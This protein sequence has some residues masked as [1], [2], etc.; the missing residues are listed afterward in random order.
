MKNQNKIYL[1]AL[2]IFLVF[3]SCKP[4][5][6]GQFS[7]FTHIKLPEN[8]SA[9]EAD[10]NIKGNLKNNKELLFDLKTIMSFHPLTF[11]T[12]DPWEDKKTNYT[13]TLLKDLLA[14]CDINE[15]ARHIQVI[16]EN[17]Y[18]IPIKLVD[19]NKYEYILAY[20][21]NGE[22]LKEKKELSKKGSFVIA[23]NFDKHEEIEMQVYKNQLVWQVKYIVV[24]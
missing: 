7:D 14:F 2:F 8:L 19:I 12:Y 3:L 4:S 9:K 18:E 15:T 20:K 6:T 5:K 1:T 24:N 21:I 22:L 10:L 13:G 23:I 11:T 17:D 16:A